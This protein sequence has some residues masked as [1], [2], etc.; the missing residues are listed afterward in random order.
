MPTASTYLVMTSMHACMQL[1]EPCTHLAWLL[2]K[3]R[4]YHSILQLPICSG[5]TCRNHLPLS[6][7]SCMWCGE[8]QAVPGAPSSR[9]SWPAAVFSRDPFRNRALVHLS[10]DRIL[11][12]QRMQGIICLSP[13]VPAWSILLGLAHSDLHDRDLHVYLLVPLYTL[14]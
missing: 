2:A 4:L 9:P 12:T 10:C 14:Y 8:L 3:A 5:H 11:K 6:A 13:Q 1:G 7:S